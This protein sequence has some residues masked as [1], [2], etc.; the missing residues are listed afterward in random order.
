[1]LISAIQKFTMLD[2]PE[3]T[4]CIVFTPGCNFR[5]GYCHNPEFVL[6]EMI[7]KIRNSFIPEDVFFHF[8][9]Q[10]I[11]KLDGVVITG[12]EPTL[13][14]D[15]RQFIEKIKNL[16]FLIKLDSNG[17]RPE[18]LEKLFAENLLDYVAM[19]V[20]TSL[21]EY[22]RLVG[23]RLD[24]NKIQKS[25]EIIMNSGVDYEF[26]ATMMKELHPAEVLESMSEMMHGAKQFF[27]QTFRPQKTLDPKFENYQA[28]SS[29]ELENIAQIF[30]KNI[31]HVYVR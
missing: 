24:P 26:R 8:L 5:C 19:D 18:V 28:F 29:S 25:I 1:M 4:A 12:G 13:M 22:P 2:Y 7:A 16:G 17:G 15:L 9:E 20:K 3:H 11:G 21:R 27:L 10:R 6:P 30:A 31:D 23:P 14:P